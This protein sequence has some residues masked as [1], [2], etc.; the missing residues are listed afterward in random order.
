MLLAE[1]QILELLKVELLH[2]DT[3]LPCA[4]WMVVFVAF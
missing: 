1:N 3:L 2:V 4:L